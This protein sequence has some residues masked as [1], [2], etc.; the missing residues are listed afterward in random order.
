MR[1]SDYFVSADNLGRSLKRDH[2]KGSWIYRRGWGYTSLA[3]LLTLG[4]LMWFTSWIGQ[5]LWH[6]MCFTSAKQ[7]LEYPWVATTQQS[8]NSCVSQVF[9]RRPL[10]KTCLEGFNDLARWAL[11]LGLLSIWWNPT[12]VNKLKLLH[13]RS[14]GKREYY[15]LQ[16]IFLLVRWVMFVPLTH[17]EVFP[18]IDAQL[19]KGMHAFMLPLNL[20]VGLYCYI[21]D[22]NVKR[23][24]S[25][26]VPYRVIKWDSSPRIAHTYSPGSLLAQKPQESR[27]MTTPNQSE[28]TAQ[29]RRNFGGSR[30]NEQIQ[31]FPIDRLGPDRQQLFSTPISPPTP[32]PDEEDDNMMDW[33]PTKR[34]YDLRSATSYRDPQQQH[35][36]TSGSEPSPFYGHLPQSVVSPAR[37]LRNPPYQPPPME[38]ASA[39]Q[40]NFFSR[41]TPKPSK[42]FAGLTNDDS[43]SP[44][45][46]STKFV[47]D[48]SPMKFANPRF[49]P[50]N[51]VQ[52]TGLEDFFA[53]ATLGKSQPSNLITSSG[54]TQEYH[55]NQRTNLPDGRGMYTYGMK[56]SDAPRRSEANTQSGYLSFGVL[57]LIAAVVIVALGLVL[58]RAYFGD[59]SVEML[60]GF[61]GYVF[62]RLGRECGLDG[63]GA[64]DDG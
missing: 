26:L 54:A 63:H 42:A 14:T 11:I 17:V 6:A 48:L 29:N 41:N 2:S 56:T 45:P 57:L 33:E 25:A 47:N 55:E 27:S 50:K 46:A 62:C 53:K 8:K 7:N 28:F 39:Q 40:H 34:Q 35:S 5:F 15:T 44:S 4:K 13:G 21:M 58:Q 10:C 30:S 49:F 22:T 38:R 23:L 36:K 32:P 52:D 12:F 61:R 9:H 60:S 20:L 18:G 59:Q 3:L 19:W 64:L 37:A 31:R 1:R 51:T 43:P 16:V 24:Q